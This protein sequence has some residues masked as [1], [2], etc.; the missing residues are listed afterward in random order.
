MTDIESAD[1]TQREGVRE[2]L[3]NLLATVKAMKNPQTI[4]DVGLLILKFAPV[5]EQAEHVL[6]AP[7]PAPA[8]SEQ[9][10]WRW[11]FKDDKPTAPW[12]F[13]TKIEKL[14]GIDILSEPL[15][16][17]PPAAEARITELTAERDEA[18][19]L[20]AVWSKQNKYAQDAAEARLETMARALGDLLAHPT[21]VDVIKAAQ[22]ALRPSGTAG[23]EG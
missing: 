23:E 8:V 20:L 4:A 10:A 6:S 16:A 21:N 2:A 18:R 22:A 13:T 12:S 7:A 5:I 14:M 17:H 11:R 9:V 19:H 3:E 1:A 15:F